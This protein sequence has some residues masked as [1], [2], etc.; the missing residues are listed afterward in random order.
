MT[1]LLLAAHVPVQRKKENTWS[2]I[3]ALSLYALMIGTASCATLPANSKGN[4][5]VPAIESPLLPGGFVSVSY[6]AR[7]T[8]TGGTA[9][10]AWAVSGGQL[11]AGLTFDRTTG[12]I[13][14]TPDQPGSFSFSAEGRD[15]SSPARTASK[16]LSITIA[17]APA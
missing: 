12:V 4:L 16:S 7:V 10:Y 15:S 11:P 9:P 17:P 3:L 8:V 5:S 1:S 2:A 14:G 13:S 6:V